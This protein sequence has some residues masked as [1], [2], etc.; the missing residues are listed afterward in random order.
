MRARYGRKKLQACFCRAKHRTMAQDVC[1]F[2][3]LNLLL[4][5]RRSEVLDA[6]CV[7]T[8][9]ARY[10]RSLVAE[11]I[12]GGVDVLLTPAWSRRSR[13]ALVRNEKEVLFFSLVSCGGRK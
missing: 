2:Y 3:A 8:S 9:I 6:V 11:N 1:G 10:G 13:W 5:V 4:R 12:R 7:Q